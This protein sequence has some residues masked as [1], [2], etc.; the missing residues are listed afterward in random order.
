[1]IYSR[2]SQRSFWDIIVANLTFVLFFTLLAGCEKNSDPEGNVDIIHDY[3]FKIG[4]V[5]ADTSYLLY[6]PSR[7]I[8]E[9]DSVKLLNHDSTVSL[10]VRK[11]YPAHPDRITE[12]Y[13]EVSN[14]GLR[15]LPMSFILSI[16]S[17]KNYNIT[18]ADTIHTD[19]FFVDGVNIH[20]CDSCYGELYQSHLIFE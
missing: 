8:Y 19:A 5:D 4:F 10:D 20:L 13:I 2:I 7:S 14:D 1:M 18:I 15:N 17:S 16:N 11:F 3:S 6:Y 12:V 9:V